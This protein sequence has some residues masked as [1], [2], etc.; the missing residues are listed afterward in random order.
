MG[1]IHW[2]AF[3]V[4][5]KTYDT[6]TAEKLVVLTGH[7]IDEKLTIIKYSPGKSCKVV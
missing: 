1:Q 2:Q 7:V 5:I 3:S 4:N 6:K